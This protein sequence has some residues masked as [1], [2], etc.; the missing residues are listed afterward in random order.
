MPS[1]WNHIIR[2]GA[3]MPSCQNERPVKYQGCNSH[4]GNVRDRFCLD[5]SVMV[6]SQCIQGNHTGCRTEKISD[7]CNDLHSED[8]FNLKEALSL[9][10]D[11]LVSAKSTL[12]SSFKEV[13]EKRDAFIKN[14]QERCDT[15]I[16]KTQERCSELKAKVN[17]I[18]NSNLSNLEEQMQTIL[19]TSFW[20]DKTITS[21]D[22]K[23][24]DKIEP[25]L[26]L[27]IQEIIGKLE[28]CKSSLA[29][30]QLEKKL[31]IPFLISKEAS[32]FISRDCQLVQVKEELLPLPILHSIPDIH[33]P[34]SQTDTASISKKQDISKIT[35]SKSGTLDTRLKEDTA[36][37]DIYGIDITN[38]GTLFLTDFNNKKLKVFS[39]EKEIPSTIP[40]PASPR[41]VSIANGKTAVVSADDDNLYF[42]NIPELDSLPNPKPVPLGFHAGGVQGHENNLIVT[43][44]KD[45]TSVKMID[46]EGNDIWSI[47]ADCNGEALFKNPFRLVKTSENDK[48]SVIVTDCGKHSLILLDANSGQ[49]IRTIS[50][51]GKNPHGLTVDNAGNL[52]VCYFRSYEIGVWSSDLQHSRILLSK[53]DL[54]GQPRLI[55]YNGASNTLY[56]SYGNKD[57]LDS[58]QLEYK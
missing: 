16:S 12:C 19:D 37:C 22:K 33:F 18:S 2:R 20:F 46:L 34:K 44:F 15:V 17:K 32:A 1:S 57:K 38:N 53:N 35:A 50:V 24:I 49:L 47:S 4:V 13:E 39:P 9:V 54:Q 30:L 58:F 7:I 6:C 28:K 52:Y 45:Q 40:L 8:I 14:V 10:S 29:I 42:I 55:C 26:F 31:V 48:A 41:D 36:A 11:N 27:R 21:I 5:H 51:E 56:I 25:N 23:L 43:R 3:R